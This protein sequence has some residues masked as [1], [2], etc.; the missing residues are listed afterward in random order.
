MSDE[1][2][3]CPEYGRRLKCDRDNYD[4]ST[5][6]CFECQFIAARIEAKQLDIELS[7]TMKRAAGAISRLGETVKEVGDQITEWSRQADLQTT[8]RKKPKGAVARL[9]EQAGDDIEQR[10]V[11]ELEVDDE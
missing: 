6:E 8:R 11:D 1:I 9:A 2:H 4:A 7:S 3:S 10:V 5:D